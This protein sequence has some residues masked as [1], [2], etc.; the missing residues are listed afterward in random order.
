MKRILLLPS[1][2]GA[3]FFA[4]CE[5]YN[6]YNF[7][8]LEEMVKPVNIAKYELE[9]TTADITT[10]VNKL[11]GLKT[12][13]DSVIAKRLNTDK[14]FSAD[15]P[16]DKLIPYILASKYLTMDKGASAKVTYSYKGETPAY[17]ATLR[18]APVYTLTDQD[19]ESAWNRPVYF[20]TSAH[21]PDIYLPVV[22]RNKY[23]AAV[24]GDVV[25]VRYRYSDKEPINAL[26][27]DFESTTALNQ[28][29]WTLTGATAW[30]RASFNGNSYAQAR[31]I[32]GTGRVAYVSPAVI[33]DGAK[34]YALSFD[35]CVG[36]YTAPC[37]RVLLSPSANP[38]DPGAE[39]ITSLFS[40]PETPATGYGT[41]VTAG[42]YHFTGRSGARHLIFVYDG[43]SESEPKRTTAYQIDKILLVEK[44]VPPVTGY[45]CD[46]IYTYFSSAWKPYAGAEMINQPDYDA[47]GVSYFSAATAPVYLPKFL[48]QKYPYALEG[49]KVA[50]GYKTS[51]TA[52]TV[53]EYIYESGGWKPST[54]VEKR[55][56]QFVFSGWEN[57]G[58]VFD[59]TIRVIMQADDYML[60]V[61]YVK[62]KY[63]AFYDSSYKDNEWYYGAD[64]YKNS[65]YISWKKAY[66]E[67]DQA[68]KDLSEG[69]RIAFLKQRTEEAVGIY[70]GLK[71]PDAIPSVNGVE[72]HALVTVAIAD[73]SV[74]V[75]YVYEY[76]CTGA[77]PSQWS[78]LSS[79]KN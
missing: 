33:L 29:G 18:G 36:Y 26:A 53:D 12:A 77:R 72:V 16:A 13:S 46:N 52:Y 1:V 9:V 49:K 70:L 41:M 42:T 69:G 58:W 6:D 57:T 54:V 4:A 37:L 21:T 10:I 25:I 71:Y 35:I 48:L 19:Y 75:K 27:E 38:D 63:P 32:T 2:V 66:R 43:N 20:L 76:K 56:D 17:L 74:T 34:E 5:D 22:L 59:P 51:A 67:K 64:A 44:D 55:T 47:M 11:N 68:F 39:D 61:N 40:I 45:V 73:D 31:I 3:L 50:V 79:V 62:D 78:F 28:H 23:P 7:P 8:G 60:I 15:V 24:E 14:M 65:V 30:T